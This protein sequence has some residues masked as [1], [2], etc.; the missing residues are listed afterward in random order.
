MKAMATHIR[1]IRNTGI[2]IILTLILGMAI[3]PSQKGWSQCCNYIDSG[4]AI[5]TLP[6]FGVALGDIDNDGVY[7]INVDTDNDLDAI[8]IPFYN[9]ASLKIY[10]NN[11][12]GNFS[13]F[14]AVSSNLGCHYAGI[15]DIDN[16]G[17]VDVML[18]GWQ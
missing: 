9:D 11:G 12:A 8:V 17:D 13:L 14:Q 10:K 16:D 3:L 18:A 7:L 6:T 2:H 1:S 5:D 4:Q 15:A